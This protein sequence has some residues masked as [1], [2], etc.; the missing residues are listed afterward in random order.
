M[1]TLGLFFIVLGSIGLAGMMVLL[2]TMVLLELTKIHDL[3]KASK[4]ESP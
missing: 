4:S 1:E 2:Q 3:L